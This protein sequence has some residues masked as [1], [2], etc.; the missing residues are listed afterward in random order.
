[1]G[2]LLPGIFLAFENPKGGCGKS[3]LTALFAGYLHSLNKYAV[4]VIDIDDTQNSLNKMREFEL[5]VKEK[6]QADEYSIMSISSAEI[7]SQRDFLQKE[8]DIILIDYPGNLK[9]PGVVKS[10]FLLDVII[11]PFEPNKMSLAP[12]LSFYKMYE[13]DI[14]NKREEIGIKTIV[15]GVPNRV[16]SNVVEYKQLIEGVDKLPFKLLDN[17][18]K[19]SKVD[20][21]RNIT[22]LSKGYSHNS[23][24]FCKEVLDLILSY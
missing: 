17:H 5:K 21:Q 16:S 12:T 20:F 18:V 8:F 22:T 23:D 4:G 10:L 3:T 2:K 15:R 7:S 1:M 13:N 11:I 14:L 19:D 24:L 6:T 9:Q